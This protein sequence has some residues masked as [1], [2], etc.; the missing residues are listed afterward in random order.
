VTSK[1]Y[2]HDEL[3]KLG[4]QVEQTPIEVLDEQPEIDLVSQDKQLSRI[5]AEESFM[6]QKLKIRVATTTDPNAP[7]YVI[8]TVNDVHNRTV[9]PRGQPVYVKRC[10]VEVLARMR[11]TRFTQPPRN[12]ADPESGNYLM[13]HH[14]TVYPFEVIEDPSPM[15]RPWLERILAEPTY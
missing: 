14:A 4:I 3:A 11:E 1:K 15:G 6:N 13:P 5:A 9:I 10:L 2:S 8:V 7:P 12:M